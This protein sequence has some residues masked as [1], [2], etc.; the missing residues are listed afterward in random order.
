MALVSEVV[1]TLPSRLA[2][3]VPQRAVQLANTLV[4]LINRGCFTPLVTDTS[5]SPRVR[6]T[7]T[8]QYSVD[9][10]AALPRMMRTRAARW[11]TLSTPY[12]TFD[13]QSASARS[14]TCTWT[15]ATPLCLSV[16]PPAQRADRI[17]SGSQMAADMPTNESSGT[18]Y[19]RQRLCHRLLSK[20][21]SS[22][23]EVPIQHVQIPPRQLVTIVMEVHEPATSLSH[24][25]TCVRR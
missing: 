1:G 2:F 11:M 6:K 25:A 23:A 14:G 16:L 20:G 15:C 13:S 18:G 8:C 10:S 19:E 22:P 4:V 17:A 5:R 12:A 24:R 21:P 9:S 7:L 3:L